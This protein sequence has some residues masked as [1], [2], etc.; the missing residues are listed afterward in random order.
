MATTTP[1][2]EDKYAKKKRPLNAREQ[3]RFAEKLRR[4]ARNKRN[5]RH[6]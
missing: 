2:K 1:N 6:G 3:R 4:N 5:A